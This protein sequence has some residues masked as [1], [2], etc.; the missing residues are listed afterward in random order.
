MENRGLS[1]VVY[2]ILFLLVAGISCW[3][4]SH[5]LHL[6][7]H[8]WPL[9]CVWGLTIAF[10][11]IASYGTKMIV[12][13]LNQNIN[14]DNR[15]AK[16]VGGIVLVLFFWLCASMPTNTHTF[17]YNQQ[18]GHTLEEDINI[19]RDYLS[20]LNDQKVID[21]AYFALKD[22]VT[23]LQNDMTDNFNGLSSSAGRRGN[24]Q[25][26]QQ[27]LQ[28]ING[29]I[30]CNIPVDT[31]Y[32]STNAE[33]IN[34]Y[35][36]AVTLELQKVEWNYKVSDSEADKAGEIIADLEVCADTIEKMLMVG[37]TDENVI[38]QV[39]GV[40]SIGYSHI[41]NNEKFVKFNNENDH[42]LYTKT[43]I[44]TRTKRMLSVIDVWIDF[45]KGEYPKSFIFWVLLSV[46]VDVAAFIFFDLAFRQRD[47][48]M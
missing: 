26:V 44:E 31:R 29:L 18:I 4:T 28:K 5:S 17:F 38:R 19:T 13:A 10:F 25:Y 22:S 21:P 11:V 48:E 7:W 47:D 43:N 23:A 41:K 33:I 32:N 2:F 42:E 12:D 27:C 39:E 46:L 14:V 16:L 36:R 6:L 34:E 40:L 9:F 1:K 20:Q 37:N 15:T 45:V 30:G 3:A 8:T 35:N 24:G